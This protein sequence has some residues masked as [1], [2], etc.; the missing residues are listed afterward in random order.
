MPEKSHIADVCKPISIE[1]TVNKFS[2]ERVTM[3]PLAELHEPDPYPFQVQD[4]NAMTTLVESVKQYGV[5]EP[6]LAR[7][8]AEGGYELLCG[9]R[10]KR[11]CEILGLTAMPV[12][13]REL[14]DQTAAVAMIDSNLQQREQLL[15]S[16][17]AWAYR[18][19]MEALNHSGVK[20][21]QNSIDI[22]VEQTGESKNQIYRLIRL[23]ELV[24]VLLDKV[25]AHELAF[26]TAVE[27]SYLS[28]EEQFIVADCMAKY[29]VRPSLSQAIRLKNLKKEEKLTT[30]IIDSILAEAKNSPV[31][32]QTTRVKYRRYFPPEYSQRDIET[33]IVELLREWKQSQTVIIGGETA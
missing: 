16:E 25:D 13:V 12:I 17:K 26:N 6:G 19:K 14:D 11:A 22:L 2:V 27:F 24:D 29:D 1:H 30:V 10:R 8:N 33:V 4:D 18:V 20:A 31:S 5:R 23:T 7:P 28:Y 9:N 15:Y 3:L 32:K 21:E